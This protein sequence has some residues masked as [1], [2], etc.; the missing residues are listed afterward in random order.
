MR[1]ANNNGFTLIELMITT[2]IIGIL[3]GLCFPM[4]INSQE[5]AQGSKAMENLHLI[6]NAEIQYRNFN[7]TFTASTAELAG[8]GQ[9]SLNDGDW[10]YTVTTNDT[11]GTSDTGFDAL[12]TR[13]SAN[14]FN[15]ETIT[16]SEGGDPTFSTGATYP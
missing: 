4:Y 10:V 6:R 7:D 2:I 16:L 9:F 1:Y 3:A 12:A 14:A 13:T 15:G 11:V 8:Y 5:K